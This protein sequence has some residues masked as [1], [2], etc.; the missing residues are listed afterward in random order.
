[1]L[2]GS[3]RFKTNDGAIYSEVGTLGD[4]DDQVGLTCSIDA[5]RR[6]KR[7]KSIVSYP[8]FED[9]AESLKNKMI[10]AMITAMLVPVA[11]PRIGGFIMDAE[12]EAVRVI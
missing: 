11:Y 9:A 7:G 6:C 10:A 4:A 2:W 3:K 8:T 5:A 1:M 12:I